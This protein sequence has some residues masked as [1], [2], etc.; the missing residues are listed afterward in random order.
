VIVTCER[1]AT[2]F[3]LD[4]SRVPPEGVR[5]RCSRCKHAFHIELPLSEAE[6]IQR[7]AAR[8]EM[9]SD[10]TQDL[11]LGSA[12]HPSIENGAPTDDVLDEEESDWEFNDDRA[13]AAAEE[14]LETSGDGPLADAAPGE[15]EDG[16]GAA[17][18]YALSDEAAEDG[19][20]LALG[21]EA[22]A[23]AAG[24]GI[25]AGAR[26]SDD[27]FAP[28][29]EGADDGSPAEGLG[30]P[31]EWDFFSNDEEPV[32]NVANELT[33]AA[34][35]L[36]S[37]TPLRV[38]PPD[39]EE[40]EEPG[41][42]RW[43]AGAARVAGWLIV[44]ALFGAGLVMGLGRDARTATAVAPQEVG[45]LQVEDVSERWVDNALSGPVLIVR[46]SLRND[47][48]TPHGAPLRIE[49]LDAQGRPLATARRGLGY[50][51]DPAR[52]REVAP[53]SLEAGQEREALRAARAPIP[54][55]GA[56]RFSAVLSGV[57]AEAAGFR[58]VVDEEWAELPGASPPGSGAAPLAGLEPDAQAPPRNP[59]LDVE[60]EDLVGAPDPVRRTRSTAEGAG[61]AGSGSVPAAVAP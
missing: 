42:S 50:E 43:L 13:R 34:E 49:L 10:S 20:S 12:V 38:L 1:C 5:V 19:E 2:Q 56:R 29:A 7:T 31:A 14:R 59:D 8:V 16:F 44:W 28:R 26:A 18:A 24:P 4:D 9:S 6:R 53:E 54:P 40:E 17:G 41:R 46:G 30:S 37:A 51:L 48:A 22:A 61:T 23:E 3:Q 35:L 21:D 25:G 60:I 33:D 27:P 55:G 11:P 45:G 39:L 57:P 58:F 52:V 15:P 47:G 36:G 32:S